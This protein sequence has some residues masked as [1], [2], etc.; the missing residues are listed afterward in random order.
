MISVQTSKNRIRIYF[1]VL[2]SSFLRFLLLPPYVYLYVRLYVLN[3]NNNNNISF[4]GFFLSF[5]SWLYEWARITWCASTYTYSFQSWTRVCYGKSYCESVYPFFSASACVSLSFSCKKRPR[6]TPILSHAAIN[7]E[8]AGRYFFVLGESDKIAGGTELPAER[9]ISPS[10][11][12]LQC[13]PKIH[14][15]EN[16]NPIRFIYLSFDFQYVGTKKGVINW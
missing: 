11:N 6:T 2:S 8:V 15:Y 9:G 16:T 4:C 14:P 3:N 5:V 10:S 13:P 7:A 12:N 1:F